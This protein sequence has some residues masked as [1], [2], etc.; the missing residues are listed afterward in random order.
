MFRSR[1]GAQKRVTF[2]SFSIK[3]N[4]KHQ[5]SEINTAG[6]SHNCR[7]KFQFFNLGLRTF[8]RN[9]MYKHVQNEQQI[10]AL[11]FYFFSFVTKFFFYLYPSHSEQ[12]TF[13]LKK[14]E[15]KFQLNT[16][17]SEP[18]NNVN[19]L[20]HIDVCASAFRYTHILFPILLHEMNLLN[21]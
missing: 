21:K 5:I 7:N 14:Q 16:F 12:I 20:H 19:V 3:L 4:F 15:N 8:Q 1:L 2:R 10:T 17:S 9:C 11:Q 6:L 13:T 18:N